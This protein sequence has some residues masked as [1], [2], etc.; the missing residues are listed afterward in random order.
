MK[1]WGWNRK[2][3]MRVS[4]SQLFVIYIIISVCTEFSRDL[5]NRHL[6]SLMIH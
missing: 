1:G 5:L 6:V 2:G 4:E 3:V